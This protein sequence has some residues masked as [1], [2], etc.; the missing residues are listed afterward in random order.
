[1]KEKL[2]QNI[3]MFVIGVILLTISFTYIKWHPGERNSFIP[4][5][6]MLGQKGQIFFYGLIGKDTRNLQIKQ[7]FNK[8]YT[9]LEYLVES[10]SCADSELIDQIRE[11]QALLQNM[12]TT[13][14]QTEQYETI[15]IAQ[16]LKQQLEEQ[17]SFIPNTNSTISDGE[18]GTG[19][20]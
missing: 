14:I 4:S 9:E 8:I 1:M 18:I 12:S 13:T 2:I 11:Q 6:Q 3:K 5:L 16:E 15:A 19:N 7:Q 10:S 20:I 17:C